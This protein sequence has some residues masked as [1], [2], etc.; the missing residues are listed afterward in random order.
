MHYVYILHSEKL[1]RF[2]VGETDN[3]V[4]R[5]D[6]HNTGFFKNS[7]TTK[8][9]DWE[10]FILINCCDRIQARKIETHIKKMKSKK[11]IQD[12]ECYP[13]IIEKLKNKYK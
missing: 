13:E 7:F 12:L 10:I 11:Y 9:S 2:Y 8:T 5:L 6:E 1:N 4:R 3:I